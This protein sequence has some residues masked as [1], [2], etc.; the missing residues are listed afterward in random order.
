[1]IGQTFEQHLR[2]GLVRQDKVNRKHAHISGTCNLAGYFRTAPGGP[3]VREG[4]NSGGMQAGFGLVE[5]DSTFNQ[6]QR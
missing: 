4:Y 1:M 3:R 5:L 2:T 6:M